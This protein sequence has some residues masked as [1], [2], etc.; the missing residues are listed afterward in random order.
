MTVVCTCCDATL[1][2]AGDLPLVRGR[3]RQ[4]DLICVECVWI[5]WREARDA[6]RSDKRWCPTHGDRRTG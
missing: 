5:V 3:P 1:V 6:P 2:R 4:G